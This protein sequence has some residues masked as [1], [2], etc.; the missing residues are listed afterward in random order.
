MIEERCAGPLY[1]FRLVVPAPSYASCQTKGRYGMLLRWTSWMLLSSLKGKAM[2]N[3]EDETPA[4][5][6][7]I[8]PD[9]AGFPPL[10]VV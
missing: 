2:V 10:G 9:P 5:E 3:V 1:S 4:Y 8:S 7:G 6:A